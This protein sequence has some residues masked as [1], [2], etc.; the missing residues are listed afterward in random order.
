MLKL[1]AIL[2]IAVGL[3]AQTANSAETE[4]ILFKVLEVFGTNQYHVGDTLNAEMEVNLEQGQSVVLEAL[5]I[6]F[7]LKGSEKS[8]KPGILRSL[9]EII[10][11][12]SR[13]K[14]SLAKSGSITQFHE[15]EHFCYAEGTKTLELW[16]SE[17]QRGNTQ[18]I[19][20][21]E[22]IKEVIIWPANQQTITI[23]MTKINEG[24]YELTVTADKSN[25]E[26]S[27]R[28]ITFHKVP[29]Q[30]GTEQLVKLAENKCERQ[31]IA[32]FTC[33]ASYKTQ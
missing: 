16:R 23:P 24:N 7:Q 4:G 15:D 28:E 29:I 18:V 27:D 21:N 12:M 2:I 20:K 25:A 22:G 8:G 11:W 10:K 13:P 5:G 1:R 30:G 26:I 3:F 17:A 32:L 6:A 19:L 14:R 33:N 9:A 31:A